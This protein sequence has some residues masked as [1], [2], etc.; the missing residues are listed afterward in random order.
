MRASGAGMQFSS[1][2]GRDPRR[3]RYKVDIYS[4]EEGADG[5]GDVVEDELELHL[6]ETRGRERAHSRRSDANA[7]AVVKAEVKSH[8]AGGGEGR[9]ANV[10]VVDLA[11]FARTDG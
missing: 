6:G 1:A 3:R 2:R 8:L 9:G 4:A 10:V 11:E 5:D 7:L